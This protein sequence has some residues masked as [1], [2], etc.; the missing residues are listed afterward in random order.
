MRITKIE[1]LKD[2]IKVAIFKS[3]KEPISNFI[4]YQLLQVL[5]KNS[6][7]YI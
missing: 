3:I 4:I 1:Y 5:L 2:A 6:S 7:K